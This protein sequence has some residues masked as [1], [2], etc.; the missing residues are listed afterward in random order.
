[1]N[2]I[3]LKLFGNHGGIYRFRSKFKK[4]PGETKLLGVHRNIIGNQQYICLLF[5]DPDLRV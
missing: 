4:D 1:M 2:T 3:N 5:V